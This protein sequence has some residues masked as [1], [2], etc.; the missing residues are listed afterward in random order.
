MV[1]LY[2]AVQ[3]ASVVGEEKCCCLIAVAHHKGRQSKKWL[4][5]FYYEIFAFLNREYFV[6]KRAFV[7]LYRVYFLFKRLFAFL[8]SEYFLIPPEARTLY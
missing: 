4:S 3:T 2:I 7:F 8:N 1:V 5:E 6:F